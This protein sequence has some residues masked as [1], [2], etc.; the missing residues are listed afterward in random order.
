M[1]IFLFTAV[2]VLESKCFQYVDFYPNTSYSSVPPTPKEN[3]IAQYL[4]DN[5]HYCYG[6]TRKHDPSYK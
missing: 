4:Q 3:A 2:P 5:R 6:S 1:F